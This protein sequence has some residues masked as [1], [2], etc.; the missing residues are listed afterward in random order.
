[1]HFGEVL[2]GWFQEGNRVTKLSARKTKLQ[3][4]TADEVR[5]AGKYR[6]VV[7][8]A[9]PRHCVLRLHGLRTGFVVS[10]A[11]V[12]SLAVKQAL[13]AEREAKKKAKR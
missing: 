10:Y 7:I 12:Y 5:E 2:A 1:M 8:E 13:A 11:A 4:V 6:A 9:H 3:F